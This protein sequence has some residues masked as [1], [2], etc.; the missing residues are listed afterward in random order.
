MQ[1]WAEEL[2]QVGGRR[3][4]WEDRRKPWTW[5]GA[6]RILSQIAP[7]DNPASLW[8]GW[9]ENLPALVDKPKPKPKT[10]TK[11]KT[12]TETKTEIKQQNTLQNCFK[13][14]KGTTFT[15]V[16]NT[17]HAEL[18][19]LLINKSLGDRSRVHMHGFEPRKIALQHP[20]RKATREMPPKPK[21]FLQKKE[22]KKETSLKCEGSAH[23]SINQIL[24]RQE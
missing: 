5:V 19:N 2:E 10:E 11:T 3:W 12:K 21:L 8:E 13:F 18:Q 7:P 14:T 9:W 20:R 23:Y 24:I 1:P 22:R 15:R 16:Q 17:S 4:Q 6:P